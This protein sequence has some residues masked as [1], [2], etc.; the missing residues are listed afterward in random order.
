[1]QIF[2]SHVTRNEVIMMQLPK[3]TEN[4]RKMRTSAKQNINRWKVI[5]ESYSKM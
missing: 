3:T 5:D 1:M 2:E 4:N